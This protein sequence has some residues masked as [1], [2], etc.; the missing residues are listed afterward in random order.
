MTAE[1]LRKTL[2][3]RVLDSFQPAAKFFGP[4][5]DPGEF[6]LL[7]FDSTGAAA[8]EQMIRRYYE[9]AGADDCCAIL[10]PCSD[11]KEFFGVICLR[12]RLMPAG[13]L[14]WTLKKAG[15][16]M[17]ELEVLRAT[18]IY[19][20]DRPRLPL[21]AGSCREV[22]GDSAV[23]VGVSDAGVA[24]IFTGRRDNG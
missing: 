22:F 6:W 24:K 19:V 7:I 17:S 1:A 4:Q 8:I 15:I 14:R 21:L 18:V 20:A 16:A 3:A 5:S 2:G 12:R 11:G 9:Q 13:H 10:R 23:I